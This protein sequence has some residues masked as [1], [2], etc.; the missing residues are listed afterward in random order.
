MNFRLSACE[1]KHI[2]RLYLYYILISIYN[3]IIILYIEYNIYA[4]KK[5]K[6]CKSKKFRSYELTLFPTRP[7]N[8]YHHAIPT[9]QNKPAQNPP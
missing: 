3:N 2:D 5:K 1:L 8:L 4:I 7:E 9:A 6:R